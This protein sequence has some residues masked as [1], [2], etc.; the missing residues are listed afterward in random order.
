[1]KSYIFYIAIF[2]CHGCTA[3]S[4]QRASKTKSNSVVSNLKTK[5]MKSHISIFEIPARDI[6]RAVDFYQAILGISI[7][8]MEM[9]EME[10]GIFPYED[11]LIT[12][13]IVKAEG[14]IPSADGV[15]IYL[16]GGE[17]LQIILGKV[18]ENGG[19]ILMKKTAHADDSG[20]FALFLD[21]EG[22]RLGLH[23]PN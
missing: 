4:S 16:N 17:D 18:E 22:N 19:E 9:P 14:Y 21:T 15:T 6:S 12:G 2:L 23:S 5:E 10:M 8:K 13:V 20:F 11:Q 1:M 7:E 3:Y